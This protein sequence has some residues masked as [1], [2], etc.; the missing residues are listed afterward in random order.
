MTRILK[1]DGK[2][3]ILNGKE[4]H[5]GDIAEDFKV[6]NT[7]MDIVN[8]Y[9]MPKGV[10]IIASCVTIESPMCAMQAKRLNAEVHISG[11]KIRSINI[12]ADNPYA[13][14]RFAFE[15]DVEHIEFFSDYKDLDFGNKYGVLMGDIRLLSRAIFVVD[16]ENVIQY[17]EYLNDN[18]HQFN[19]NQAVQIA[20]ELISSNN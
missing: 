1:F 9:D 10:T 17:A 7:D 6:M 13:L 3:H 4:R 20:K 5:F 15:E 2:D 18:E 19:Y 11:K 14:A 16:S 12:S 8:F